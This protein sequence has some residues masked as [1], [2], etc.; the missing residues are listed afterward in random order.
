MMTIE[1]LTKRIEN[2]MK[3]ISKLEKKLERILKA[4]ESNYE[5][6]NPYY[7]SDCD[8]RSTLRELEEAKNKLQKYENE[9]QSAQEKEN[10]RKVQI[11]IDF[12]ISWKEKLYAIYEN[13]LTE[14]YQMRSEIRRLY[15]SYSTPKDSKE[16]LEW[17]EI[18]KEYNKRI[19]GVYSY[20][21]CINPWTSLEEKH[22]VKVE[23]GCW[24][25][26]SYYLNFRT[27]QE[28]LEQAEKDIIV[29]MNR[30]YD[31]IIQRTNKFVGQIEDVSNLHFGSNGELNGVIIGTKGKAKV[32]T[33]IAD[34]PIRITHFRVLVKEI[35]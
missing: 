4:E 1:T 30:K 35:K 20:E 7:Y 25:Y 12:L 6:N 5:L 13:D 33:I 27:L 22:K 24:E 32:T 14:A 15:P 19:K 16:Y 23:E 18:N 17:Q 31:F 11:I 9:L 26:L 28:A 10:S 2:A 29:E 21:L 3:N 8:K 34:G